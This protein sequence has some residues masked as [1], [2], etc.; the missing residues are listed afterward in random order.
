MFQ[1]LPA[2]GRSSPLATNLVGLAAAAAVTSA[3]PVF[4]VEAPPLLTDLLSIAPKAVTPTVLTKALRIGLTIDKGKAQKALDSFEAAI[5][6]ADKGKPL[7]SW[8]HRPKRFC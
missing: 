5:F 8:T 7:I 4:A 6:T 1:C 2:D 3:S